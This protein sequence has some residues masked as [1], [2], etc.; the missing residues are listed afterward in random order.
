[1]WRR[2][3]IGG[4]LVCMTAT[5]WASA[6]EWARGDKA[7]PEGTV[8]KGTPPPKNLNKNEWTLGLEA[9]YHVWC[10]K[11]D[12]TKH[13]RWTAWLANGRK[14]CEGE[15]RNGK[16]CGR[17]TWWDRNGKISAIKEY[18]D[19]GSIIKSVKYNQD[20][21]LSSQTSFGKG[22]HKRKLQAYD[23]GQLVKITEFEKGKPVIKRVGGMAV[24]WGQDYIKS[25]TYYGK[26]GE[27]TKVEVYQEGK[28]LKT[29]EIDR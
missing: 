6:T 15:H 14:S 21:S 29:I 22:S 27:V 23:R 12:G 5:L 13:G 28:F 2:T 10:E 3:V 9:A 8:L 11:P 7:C 19:D 18:N 17:W 26:D 16:T 20:G 25:I 4:L 24:R 1:M